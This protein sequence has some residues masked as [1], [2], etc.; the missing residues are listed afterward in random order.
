MRLQN[1][2]LD[3]NLVVTAPLRASS[4]EQSWTDARDARAVPSSLFALYCRADYL[5]F[6]SAPVFLADSENLLFSYFAM[7]LRSLKDLL[8]EAQ[9]LV[10]EFAREQGQT[11][12]PGKKA[13]GEQW[14]STANMRARRTFKYLMVPLSRTLDS[15]ADLVALFF[16]GR[17][18]SLRF[19]RAQ[20]SRI[21]IWLQ[22]SFVSS[23]LVVTPYEHH[24]RA[25]YDTLRPLVLADAPEPG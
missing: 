15:L 4:P 10:A 17:I 25:L 22:G 3:I 14:D 16:T 7:L 21:E 23:G 11:Y 12:D 13:R 1:C 18:P 24:L 9:E 19:G 20:F 6:G 5:S 2:T 8:V